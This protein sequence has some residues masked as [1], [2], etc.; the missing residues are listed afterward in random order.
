[1]I[2]YQFD[3]VI[4]LS[5]NDTIITDKRVV[6]LLHLQ[7][8]KDVSERYISLTE[9][10]KGPQITNMFPV[11]KTPNNP[12]S[13]NKTITFVGFYQ[14]NWC[15]SDFDY[16][17]KHSNY[18]FNFIVWADPRYP[19]LSSYK[20]IKVL[21]GIKTH[22]L[23]N[24]ISAST[25]I[26]SRNPLNINYDRFSGCFTLA[27]S[28]KKPLIVDKKTQEAYGFPGIVFDQKYSEVV[29]RLNSISKEEYL[30]LVK[31]GEE[32]R[33]KSIQKNKE[34]MNYFFK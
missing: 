32:F 6:S 12:E 28:F 16:F 13:F 33:E 29:E 14:D 25:F 8:L 27:T 20:N 23:V 17:I 10:I 24:I 18:T 7:E 22:E 2:M 26:L 31:Q 15:D 3:L 9:F 19:K 1:M 4:K 5:S 34:K 30:D 11:Y 21:Q